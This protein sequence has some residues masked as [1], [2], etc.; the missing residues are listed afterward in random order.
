MY[1]FLFSSIYLKV[2]IVDNV[3]TKLKKII[4]GKYFME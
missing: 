2:Y 4:N 3:V 1:K